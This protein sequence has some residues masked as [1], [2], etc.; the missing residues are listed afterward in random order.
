MGEIGIERDLFL[1]TLKLWELNAIVKG[2][3]K[4]ERTSWSQVRWMT[5]NLMSVSMADLKSN[6]IH[7]PTDL[8]KF[9]WDTVRRG[10][11]PS[12][13]VVEELQ[14]LIRDVNSKKDES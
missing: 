8:I 7:Q 2:Y 11:E 6:G 5:F 1:H 10:N 9:P 13:E 12:E 3:R 14:A 4:R